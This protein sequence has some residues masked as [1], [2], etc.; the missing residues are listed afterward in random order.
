MSVFPP[1]QVDNLT[2][3]AS[4]AI[5]VEF[6]NPSTLD[7]QSTLLKPTNTPVIGTPLPDSDPPV[8]DPAETVVP[9]PDV[10]PPI[11]DP[12]E[13]YHLS[14]ATYAERNPDL[15]VQPVRKIRVTKLLDT[16]KASLLL[17]QNVEQEEHQKLIEE[18]DA[19]LQRNLQEQEDLAM[20]FSIKPEF[21]EKLKGTS[22]H[23]KVKR[24]VNIENAKIHAK[25]VEINGGILL[26]SLLILACSD[27]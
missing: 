11:L 6:P 1:V 12:A 19:L 2:A 25:S 20:K 4:T 22:K 17:R 14:L 15:F 8:L 24:S 18:F 10:D 3:L 23:F 16:Q 7:S 5:P 21:L 27:S 13:T 9:L 26:Y